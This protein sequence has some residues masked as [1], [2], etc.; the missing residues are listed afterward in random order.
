MRE[1]TDQNIS[2]EGHLC[3]EKCME[4]KQ[5]LRSTYIGVPL[6]HSSRNKTLFRQLLTV[7]TQ[8]VPIVDIWMK[9]STL[10]IKYF[11]G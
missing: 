11:T 3:K 10:S 1:N 7:L 2:E 8:Y 5:V 6:Y 9:N 4:N